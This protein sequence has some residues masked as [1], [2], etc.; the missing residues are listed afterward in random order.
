MVLTLPL[1]L[2]MRDP[3]LPPEDRCAVSQMM[4]WH[5]QGM[6]TPDKRATAG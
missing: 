6:A 1:L 5:Y 4:L 2:G 3:F